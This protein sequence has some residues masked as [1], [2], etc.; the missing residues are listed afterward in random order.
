MNEQTSFLNER[1][2]TYKVIESLF[3]GMVH[4]S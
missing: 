2:V 1:L 3:P 4:N